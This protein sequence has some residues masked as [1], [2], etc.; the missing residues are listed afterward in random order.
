E[1]VSLAAPSQ[2]NRLAGARLSCRQSHSCASRNIK[3]LALG[4]LAVNLQVS[5][6]LGKLEVGSDL[7]WAVS[8]VGY[9]EGDCFFALV[10]KNF[11]VA[12]KMS[13]PGIM[14]LFSCATWC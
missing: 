9:L 7:N 13:S 11:L 3:A 10:D 14:K 2:S 12:L 6:R 1:A 4:R 5:I 8:L